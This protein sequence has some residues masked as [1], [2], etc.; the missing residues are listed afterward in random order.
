MSEE[1][2]EGAFFEIY[3]ELKRKP[4]DVNKYRNKAGQGR[5]QAF[6]VVNKRCM[7]ADASRQNWLRP[8]L[9]Y[10]LLEFGKKYVPF[11]FNAITVN[12]NYQ[13]A[14]HRDKRNDG[15]SF[16]VAFGEFSGGEL[17]IH[18]GPYLGLHNIRHKP[19]IADFSTMLHS[20]KPFEGERY[21]LVFYKA[22]LKNPL[23]EFSVRI[24]D[25]E[26]F[27]FRGDQKITKKNP[28]PHPLQKKQRNP[29]AN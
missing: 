22:T 8:K 5:S 7:P 9:Y 21:S 11:E 4:L 16:L 2:P 20:V 28:L 12:C 18:E 24:E 29:E 6:G 26:Y 19:I 27:F 15:N 1:I 23:P 25:G 13:A 14:P 3:T 17:E 10:H